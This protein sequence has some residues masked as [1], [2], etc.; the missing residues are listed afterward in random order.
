MRDQRYLGRGT[1]AQINKDMVV[2]KK[3]GMVGFGSQLLQLSRPH[4]L[5]Q[6]AGGARNT[7]STTGSLFKWEEERKIY[8]CFTILGS[9]PK[10]T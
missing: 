7:S 2:D 4:Q 8:S 10:E 6:R 3:K 9:Q 5:L 1:G